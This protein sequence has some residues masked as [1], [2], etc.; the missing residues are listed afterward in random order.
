MTSKKKYDR[1][2]SIIKD[3][4]GYKMSIFF[5][6]KSIIG[7]FLSNIGMLSNSDKK[8]SK[9]YKNKESS[10]K[11]LFKTVK[12]YNLELEKINKPK[13]KNNKKEIKYL[14]E[15]KEVIKKVQETIHIS[16][17]R[18]KNTI[19]LNDNNIISLEEKIKEKNKENMKKIE[20][21]ANFI[22]TIINVSKQL[23]KETIEINTKSD[24]KYSTN[25]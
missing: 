3:C 25:L 17:I 20:N 6:S 8:Q 12:D 21:I 11:A 24:K 4:N 9:S 15:K 2:N 10:N 7:N 1:I 23:E 19:Y 13:K 5:K 18:E 22:D 16:K 14:K